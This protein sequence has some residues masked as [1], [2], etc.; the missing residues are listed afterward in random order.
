[1]LLVICLLVTSSVAAD[2][3]MAFQIQPRYTGIS[4]FNVSFDIN[5]GVAECGSSVTIPGTSNTGKLFMNLLRSTDGVNW[6]GYKTW[7][8]SGSVL[9]ELDKDYTV[10]H[11]YYYKVHCSANVYDANGTIIGMNTKTSAIIYY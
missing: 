8:A 2:E 3:G 7:S 1:M 4:T 11:G 9:I 10:A 5:N 6:S